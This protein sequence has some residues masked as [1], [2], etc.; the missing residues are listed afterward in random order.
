MEPKANHHVRWNSPL[1]LR[2]TNPVYSL[3]LFLEGKR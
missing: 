3:I 1:V 2:Q